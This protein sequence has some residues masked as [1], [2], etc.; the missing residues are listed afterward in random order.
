MKFKEE[1]TGAKN[2]G[3]SRNCVFPKH[4]D[5]HVNVAATRGW[6]IATYKI[7]TGVKIV[8]SGK[9]KNGFLN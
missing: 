8:K 9:M 4:F 7:N 5:T 2:S 1:L 3:V 6:V